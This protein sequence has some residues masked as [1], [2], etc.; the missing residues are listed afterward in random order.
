MSRKIVRHERR[1]QILQALH[2]C[3]K[4]KPFHKTSIKDIAQKAG[5]NHGMLHYYFENKEDIL[6]KYIDFTYDRYWATY[7]EQFTR[8]LKKTTVTVE[9]LS[10]VFHWILNEISFDPVE[11]RIFTEIWSLAVYS[12]SVMKKI[13]AHYR[14]WKNQMSTLIENIVSDKKTA[15]KLSLSLIAV[16]EGMS[17]LSVFFRKNDLCIDIDLPMMMQSLVPDYKNKM[18]MTKVP[19]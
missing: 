4:E 12:P 3:L 2:E 15:A 8:K 6:L 9:T 11:S 10:E 18:I 13:K 16:A 14:R 7:S 19:S 17:L 1:N 5:I